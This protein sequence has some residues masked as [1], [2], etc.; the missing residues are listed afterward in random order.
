[1]G[2]KGGGYR[3]IDST[4]CVI[5]VFRDLYVAQTV[6]E[7]LNT[8]HVISDPHWRDENQ[9]VIVW[10]HGSEAMNT[11]TYAIQTQS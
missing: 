5:A 6:A 8:L 3:L 9:M 11:S 2:A 1:M 4:G 10:R 7:T